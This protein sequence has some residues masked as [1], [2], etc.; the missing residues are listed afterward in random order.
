MKI[1]IFLSSISIVLACL[2]GYLAF[3]IAE[4]NENDTICGVGS[5]VCFVTMKRINQFSFFSSLIILYF[6]VR[7]LFYGIGGGVAP[8]IGGANR[9]ANSGTVLAAAQDDMPCFHTNDCAVS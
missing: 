2:F 5:G 8:G 9:L 4:G 6:N 7:I 3:N 1:N